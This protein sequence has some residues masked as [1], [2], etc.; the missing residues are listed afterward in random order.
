MPQVKEL[1]AELQGLRERALESQG[2]E[3]QPGE[4]RDAEWAAAVT[5]KDRALSDIV[6]LKVRALHP[7]IRACAL[8]RGCIGVLHQGMCVLQTCA[9]LFSD[10]PC[11]S[12]GFTK[13]LGAKFVYT[14]Q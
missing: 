6:S 2:A 8:R 1:E 10:G 3:V 12:G 14:V 5:E 7:T 11:R 4:T 9:S 13:L